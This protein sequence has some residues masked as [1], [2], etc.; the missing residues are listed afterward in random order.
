M[1]P[2]TIRLATYKMLGMIGHRIYGKPHALEPVQRLPFGLYLKYPGDPEG[3]RNEL[4]AL[5]MVRRYTS[6][7]RP[8]D[9]IIVTKESDEK[10]EA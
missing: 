4:N 10:A 5:K 6:V 3:F 8:I 2:D 7:P 9:L 1:V